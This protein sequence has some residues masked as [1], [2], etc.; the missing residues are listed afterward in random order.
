MQVPL[1]VLEFLWF[2]R[3]RIRFPWVPGRLFYPLGPILGSVFLWQCFCRQKLPCREL[4]DSSLFPVSGLGSEIVDLGGLV[5]SLLPQ[6]P[7][8]KVRGVA[9]H[10]LQGVVG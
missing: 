6:N 1:R 5:G 2:S 4:Q 7:L 8:E 10:L 3:F 9:C